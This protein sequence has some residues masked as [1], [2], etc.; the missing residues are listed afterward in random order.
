MLAEVMNKNKFTLVVSLPK[1]DIELVKEA[2]LGGADAV[3]VHLNVHHFASGVKYGSFAQEKEFLT[4]AYAL[5]K[6]Q[7]KLLGVVPGDGG[8]YA[9]KEDIEAMGNL[10]VDFMSTYVEYAPLS[11]LK[12]K[13]IELC[14][15]IGPD[16]QSHLKE[17]CEIETDII[18]ASI[19]EQSDYR[20]D[21]SVFDLS[22]Y[23]RIVAGSNKPVLV[24]TQKNI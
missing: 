19:M 10:G 12:N 13:N 14:G 4:E 5:V 22:K 24:P 20:K 9:S 17:L 8:E 1:N 11:L 2:L 15:A 16:T 18:E 7:G 23:K 6:E 3:K 21:L